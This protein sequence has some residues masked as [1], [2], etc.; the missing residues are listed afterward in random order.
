LYCIVFTHLSQA[1]AQ[2]LNQERQQRLEADYLRALNEQVK[3]RSLS[4]QRQMEEVRLLFSGMTFNRGQEMN[5]LQSEFEKRD[6]A[7]WTNVQ[8]IIEDE[9]RRI[10]V[11]KAEEERKVKEEL[12]RRQREEKARQ[13]AQARK[14]QQEK[15]EKL[16]KELESKKLQK[17]AEEQKAREQRQQQEAVEQRKQAEQ[18]KSV[19]IRPALDEWNEGRELLAKLKQE[20]H[21]A[22]KSNPELKSLRN[23]LRRQITP[24]IGQLTNE[25]QQ[26]VR[27][28]S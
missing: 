10:A 3:Q 23:K 20:V 21:P 24:K 13:E 4:H 14:E 15:E 18:L 19:G 28:V 2:K 26:I 1:N 5:R 22:I 25:A 6:R 27:V 8:Q 16:K 7:L 11:R 17:E 9:E 12:V